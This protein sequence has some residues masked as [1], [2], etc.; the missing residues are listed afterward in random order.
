MRDT[1]MKVG[2]SLM[3]KKQLVAEKGLKEKM[4]HSVMPPKLATLLMKGH[5]EDVDEG[6]SNVQLTSAIQLSGEELN[7]SRSKKKKLADDFDMHSTSDASD[8]AGAGGGFDMEFG[9]PHNGLRKIYYLRRIPKC[10]NK[11]DSHS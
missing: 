1:F 10:M 8:A 6:I 2:Q 9:G 5:A 7:K 3:V 4:I 11:K